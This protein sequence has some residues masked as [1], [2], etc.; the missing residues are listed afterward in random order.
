MTKGDSVRLRIDEIL[1]IKP[2]LEDYFEGIREEG[3]YYLLPKGTSAVFPKLSEIEKAL[4]D[5]RKVSTALKSQLRKNEFFNVALSEFRRLR[6]KF[7]DQLIKDDGELERTDLIAPSYSILEVIL[8]DRSVTYH[9]FSISTEKEGLKIKDL[10]A[11]HEYVG[12]VESLVGQLALTDFPFSQTNIAMLMSMAN[13]GGKFSNQ[14]QK[15]TSDIFRKPNFE[16]EITF[17]PLISQEVTITQQLLSSIS[18]DYKSDVDRYVNTWEER[19]V[20]TTHGQVRAFGLGDSIEFIPN[21]SEKQ[22]RY[23]RE[24]VKENIQKIRFAD[25]KKEWLIIFRSYDRIGKRNSKKTNARV[26][27]SLENARGYQTN[28]TNFRKKQNTRLNVNWET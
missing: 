20:Y 19:F 11:G 16:G 14:V 25:Y 15:S 26:R 22:I 23:V 12:T 7:L 9:P 2:S 18:S 24:L 8:G 21:H 3:E 13:Q 5:P 1:G 10:V 6:R 17:V 28:P 27:E 4:S